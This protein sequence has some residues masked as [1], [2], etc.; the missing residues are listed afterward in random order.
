MSNKTADAYKKLFRYIE[1]NVFKLNPTSFM[2][3]FEGG[4]RKAI[5]E[6]YI[7]AI[8]RGCW[9]HFKAAVRRN[10][11]RQL[12]EIIAE[13]TMAAT[14][15]RMLLSLPLLPSDKINEGFQIIKRITATNKLFKA[16]QTFFEYFENF[17]LQ[18]V[19]CC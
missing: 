10:V 2:A 12:L 8:L 18:M 15:Y 4:I 14:I 11:S 6:F 1:D 16:F 5:T 7:N 17:W 9:F 19:N 13:S 3:D